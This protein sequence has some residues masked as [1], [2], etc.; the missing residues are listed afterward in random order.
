MGDDRKQND[1]TDHL[2]Q[3]GNTPNQIS[4]RE[5]MK[6]ALKVGAYATPV[7]LAVARPANV[8]AQTGPTGTLSG[9]ISNASNG[10][11]ISGATVAVGTRTTTTSGTG[12]YTLTL[13]PAGLRAVQTSAT[14]FIT[15]TDTVNVV[16]SATTT[17][18]TALVPVSAG[19]NISIVL[20][21]GATPPDLDS[22]LVG[23]VLPSGRF[24]CY[25]GNP[26]P[27][28]YVS[29]DLDD[30]N[31]F[32]PE[33]I[34]VTTSGGNM[35]PGSYN[36]YVH[37]YSSGGD[38]TGVNATV[39]VFQGGSQIAQYVSSGAT[40]GPTAL[41]WS[42]FNFTLTATPTG[43]IVLAAVQTLTNT[44]PTAPGEVLRPKIRS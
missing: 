35:V 22:H 20:T 6:T 44:A 29:L 21:W 31:G 27:V 13:V 24:H 26:N 19:G 36:Y 18:S 40:G 8:A 9:V 37:W 14:G 25:Y 2:E 39:T 41:Y 12:A 11:P 32:G 42:V 15:R 38:W 30:T 7:V 3:D 33:T 34:T 17:F 10:A 4:R 16:A 43:N 23:P 1:V 28:P 5:A